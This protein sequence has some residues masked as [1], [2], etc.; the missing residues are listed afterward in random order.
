[1]IAT[2]DYAD[3][4]NIV[5]EALTMLEEEE[6][7]SDAPLALTPKACLEIAISD[8]GICDVDIFVEDAN[9]RKFCSVH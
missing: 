9:N 1:M 7:L 2:G 3:N 5:C 6:K 4:S 8:T